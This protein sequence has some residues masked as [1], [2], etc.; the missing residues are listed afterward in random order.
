MFAKIRNIHIALWTD[1]ASRPMLRY[2]FGITIVMLAA[3]L[4][5]GRMAYLIP[6]LS[7]NF[8]VPGTK[9]PTLK[10]SVSF[11][12]IVAVSMMAGFLFVHFLYDFTAVFVLLTGTFLF[13]IFY[14]DKIGFPVKLFMII[15]LLA[16]P[17][18]AST[19]NAS[20]WAYVVGMVLLI[21]S[22]MSIAVSWLVF[23][24]FPDLPDPD[25]VTEAPVKKPN[26]KIE[27]RIRLQNAIETF[28][29]TFPVVLLFLFFQWSG[30]LLVLIYVV[31]FSMMPGVVHKAGA[32]RILGNLA[33]GIATIIFYQL[34][35]IV[36]NLLFFTML[37]LGTAL[38]FAIYIFSE[39]PFAPFLKT[40]FSVLVMIIGES[41]L[42]TA[43][44]GVSVWERV[45]Q[46]MIAIAYVIV[47]F[48]VIEAF[49]RNA[50]ERKERNE[51]KKI[52]A[53]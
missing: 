33:G 24:L 41:T 5:G 37:F 36:P 6:F 46:V 44:A 28:I 2:A 38:L 40:G 20:Q 49:K 18:H 39:S 48:K 51:A 27:S 7:L 16:M 19:M 29:I 32:V 26:L 45:F 31:I 9:Q 53:G 42:S 47:G 17:V 34:I 8:L 35:V 12:M 22:L 4:F 25:A 10:G 13:L 3:L 30:A 1:R 23:A 14:T 43:D 52:S 15:A 50:F 11:L 21:G